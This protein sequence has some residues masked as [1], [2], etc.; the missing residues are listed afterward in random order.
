MDKRELIHYALQ[1]LCNL[2][3]SKMKY[4]LTNN[5]DNVIITIKSNNIL[6]YIYFFDTGIVRVF[7]KTT[8][9]EL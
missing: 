2:K 8:E 6:Y 7:N 1:Y 3:S 5:Y 4:T 9:E